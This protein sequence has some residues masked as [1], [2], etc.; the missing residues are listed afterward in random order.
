MLTTA[1]PGC[2]RLPGRE[3]G[4]FSSYTQV[5]IFPNPV[6][7][8]QIV[9]PALP[10]RGS[11]LSTSI[12][13]P[14]VSTYTTISAACDDALLRVDIAVAVSMSN[15]GNST[16]RP[17][18]WAKNVVA[19]GGIMHY[20]TL[21]REDDTASQ[22]SLGPAS[23]G[24]IKPDVA[25]VFDNVVTVLQPPLPPLFSGTSASTPI[26]AGHAG[27]ICQ[28][29]HERAFSG[30]GGGPSV[31]DDRPGA[32]TIRALPGVPSPRG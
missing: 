11:F 7:L 12:G 6:H 25:H 8:A 21:T 29:W 16:A 20:D 13:S 17:Q 27:L 1:E 26:V 19:V 31:F 5:G 15:T 28:L 30:F 23:D 9:D 10:Y 22:S 32:A 4:I 3:Q 14:Q 2:S 18:A 24:R